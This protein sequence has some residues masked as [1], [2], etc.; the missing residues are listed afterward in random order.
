MIRKKIVFNDDTQWAPIKKEEIERLKIFNIEYIGRNCL[1]EGDYIKYAKDADIIFNQG[2]HKITKKIIEN[3]PKLKAIIRRGIGYDN[4]DIKTATEK[5]I[6]VSNTPGFC[7]DEVSTHAI[8]LLLSF[9]RNIPYW[10]N[11]IRKGEW[12]EDQLEACIDVDSILNENVGIIGF[13]NI[14]RMIADKLVP[15]KTNIYV[16]DPYVL[17]DKKCNVKKVK[18]DK[19]LKKSKYIILACPLTEETVNILDKEQFKLIRNDAVIIN[20]GRGKLINEKVLIKYLKE[21]LIKGAALDV[22]KKEPVKKDNLLLQFDNVIVTPHNAA[23]SPKSMKK[24]L[25][26]AFDEI[27][28]IVRGKSP[29]CKVN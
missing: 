15:F 24:S 13:G 2:S 26:I 14:G 6:C 4:I 5:C 20:V 27:I 12:Q 10:Y 16:Y 3:L 8:A 11:W 29:I 19:L 7:V 1:V 17:V 22:F 21:K 28:R 23:S 25:N 18:L 9:V